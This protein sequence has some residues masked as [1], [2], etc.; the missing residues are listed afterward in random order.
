MYDIS[1]HRK[2]FTNESVTSKW[3]IAGS[4]GLDKT[5]QIA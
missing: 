4:N 3:Y 2:H 5:K 1:Q